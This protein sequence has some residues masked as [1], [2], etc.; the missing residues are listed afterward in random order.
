MT[1]FLRQEIQHAEECLILGKDWI[2]LSS[3]FLF[4]NFSFPFKALS[5]S[6]SPVTVSTQSCM[7]VFSLLFFDKYIWKTGK[8]QYP[9]GIENL[10]T[11]LF[12]PHSVTP[13]LAEGTFFLT[14]TLPPHWHKKTCVVG[15][16]RARLTKNIIIIYL[17]WSWATCWPVPVSRI[18]K[19]LQR[20]TKIPSASWGVVFHYPG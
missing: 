13:Q 5:P 6:V 17:S 18:Q 20:S 14:T 11:G 16:M 1:T 7:A 4:H 2:L 9:L 10:E 15:D 8:F 3:I 19:S 12:Q